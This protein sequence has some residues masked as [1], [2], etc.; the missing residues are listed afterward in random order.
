MTDN[1]FHHAGG[2]IGRCLDRLAVKRRK[3]AADVQQGQVM[4]RVTGRVP[5]FRQLLQRRAPHRGLAGLAADMERK[6]HRRQA[7]RFGVIQQA[8]GGVT[9]AAKLARQWPVGL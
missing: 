2:V 1:Q 3:T 6:P 7:Q 5:D 4:A 9:V 8:Q